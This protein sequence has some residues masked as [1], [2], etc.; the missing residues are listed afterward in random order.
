MVLLVLLF[1]LGELGQRVN[2]VDAAV[3]PEVNKNYFPA[4]VVLET[5]RRRHVEPVLVSE[6]ILWSELSEEG[7]YL[8]VL[9][10]HLLLYTLKIGHGK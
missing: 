9:R 2:A 1:H 7:I 8:G 4:E 3:G 5:E 6:D 10:T